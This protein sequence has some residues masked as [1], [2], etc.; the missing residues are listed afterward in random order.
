MEDL[1]S[2]KVEEREAISTRIGDYEVILGLAK[3]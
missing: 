2:Y 3:Y 1:A